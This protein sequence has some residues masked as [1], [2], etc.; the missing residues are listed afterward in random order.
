MAKCVVCTLENMVEENKKRSK[1]V[2]EGDKVLLISHY[3]TKIVVNAL[4]ERRKRFD[5]K[6][7]PNRFCKLHGDKNSTDQARTTVAR[8]WE[9]DHPNAQA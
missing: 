2:K 7:S 4:K 3:P 9:R 8:S 6:T 5:P 1:V